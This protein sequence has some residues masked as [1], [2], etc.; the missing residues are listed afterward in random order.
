MLVCSNTSNYTDSYGDLQEM[1]IGGGSKY[2][3]LRDGFILTALTPDSDHTHVTVIAYLI[4]NS[5]V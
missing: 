5:Q 1:N 4:Q 2:E 3:K